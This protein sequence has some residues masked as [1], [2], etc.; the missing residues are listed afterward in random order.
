MDDEIRTALAVYGNHGGH[1][2][3]YLERL[4][5]LAPDTVPELG[6]PPGPA[7]EMT[8]AAAE[9]VTAA[10]AS[11]NP[12]GAG[13]YAGGSEPR[14][15]YQ[16]GGLFVVQPALQIQGYQAAE[17]SPILRRWYGGARSCP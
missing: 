6:V 8:A 2:H 3:T 7:L 11:F 16:C 4:H 12:S 14:R 9:A 5:G 10:A 13:S 17:P 15:P 1:V